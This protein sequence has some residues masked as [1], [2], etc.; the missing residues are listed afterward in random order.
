MP[1]PGASPIGP[2]LNLSQLTRR[3]ALYL[4]LMAQRV[5]LKIRRVLSSTAT[6]QFD[7]P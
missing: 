2:G 3:V 6:G 5:L 1:Q 7:L 4:L